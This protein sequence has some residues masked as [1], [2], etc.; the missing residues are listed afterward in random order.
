M[1]HSLLYITNELYH[2]PHIHCENWKLHH[3]ANRFRHLYFKTYTT[4]YSLKYLCFLSFRITQHTQA[5]F[6]QLYLIQQHKTSFIVFGITSRTAILFESRCQI[7]QLQ[8]KAKNPNKKHLLQC[9]F[10][11]FLKQCICFLQIHASWANTQK[12]STLIRSF[13]SLNYFTRHCWKLE[14]PASKP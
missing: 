6:L 2:F 4:V 3:R 10:F 13:S 1:K 7:I 12:M 9:I 8:Y 11:F 14:A 5:G